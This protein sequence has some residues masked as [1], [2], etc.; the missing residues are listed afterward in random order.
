[1]ARKDF[2]DDGYSEEEIYSGGSK[3]VQGHSTNL[4]TTVPDP[5]MAAMG[6]LIS[7]PDWPEYKTS[8]HFVRDAIFHRLHWTLRQTDR[9]SNDRVKRLVAMSRLTAEINYRAMERET[10][11]TLLTELRQA[12]RDAHADGDEM[13]VREMIKEVESTLD[14]IP[15][16]YRSQIGDEVISWDRR[17]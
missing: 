16:P 4:R 14:Q 17:L 6:E 5:W 7:S 11:Q 1:M 12:F 15:Q 9:K 13:G 10:Y 3:D 2:I 8:Q